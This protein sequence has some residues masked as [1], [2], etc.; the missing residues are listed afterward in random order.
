VLFLD[1]YT[2]SI[3]DLGS[4]NGTIVNGRRIGK[5][6]T[7]LLHDDIISIGDMNILVDLSR[8]KTGTELADSETLPPVSPNALQ[9]TGVFE[10][11][12]LQAEIP[13]AIPPPASPSPV[14]AP[15]IPIASPPP[16]A[17]K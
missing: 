6:V 16:T 17:E 10:G 12:T 1:N 3:R 14:S 11:D 8:A 9:A 5:G 4:K 15:L 13:G 7:T 2:L